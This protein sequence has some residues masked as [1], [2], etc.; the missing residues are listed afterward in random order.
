M[1]IIHQTVSEHSLG[2]PQGDDQ[3]IVL[4]RRDG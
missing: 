3:T 4:A 1:E 2:L